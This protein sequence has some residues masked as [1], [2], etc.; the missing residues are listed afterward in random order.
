MLVISGPYDIP[1]AL[2]YWC[3]ISAWGTPRK[4][5]EPKGPWTNVPVESGLVRRIDAYLDSG[6]TH[7]KSRP[8]VVNLAVE[9]WLQ[10]R[11]G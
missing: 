1:Y 6:K 11:G 7:L 10:R 4:R 8:S 3:G 2:L 9:E 5:L